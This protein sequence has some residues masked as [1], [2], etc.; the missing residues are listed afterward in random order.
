MTFNLFVPNIATM[1][2][3]GVG[4]DYSLVIVTRFREE[5]KRSGNPAEAATATVATAGK[6]VF[7]SGMIVILSLA[8]LLLVD[9]PLFR[10]LAIGAMTSVGV[11]VLGALTLLPAVLGAAGVS[12]RAPAIAVASPTLG[13]A[14]LGTIVR[15]HRPAARSLGGDGA[16]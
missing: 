12:H 3:L 1:I 10:E 14:R 9:A 8:G 2:G 11:M 7:F 13:R 5:L 16:R 6:T 15:G 4:I